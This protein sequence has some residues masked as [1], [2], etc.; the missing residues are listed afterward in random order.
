MVFSSIP[1]LYYFLPAVLAVYF[2]CL[3]RG[4]NA[5]LLAFS[6]FFY[7][8][9]ELKFLLLMGAAIIQGYVF[10]I[11][12]D[13][14]QDKKRRRFAA[15]TS[16]GIS[17]GILA[18]FKY[19]GFFDENFRAATGLPLPPLQIALPVGVSFYTF[20]ILSYTA[21]VYRRSIPAERNLIHF[22]CYVSMFP[23]L[24][25]GPIVRYQDIAGELK[26]RSA[27]L[28][29]VYAGLRRFL[30]GLGKKVLL[31]DQFYGLCE[32]FQQSAEKP[33]L[34]CWMHAA[35]FALYV[36]YDFSGYSDM[37]IGMG[38]MLGFTFPENFHYPF[39]SR[40]ASEF[41]RRW[42][43]TL[44]G[45]FRDYVYIPLGGSRRG[46]LRWL[47]NLFVVWFLT[48]L[49]HGAAWNF[50]I[51]GLFFGI[52]TAAEKL[53]YGKY[54]ERL[55]R[56]AAGFYTFLF[57]TVSFVIFGSPSVRAALDSV[58]GLFGGGGRPFNTPEAAYYLGSFAPL[59]FI[60]VLGS[61]PAP[62]MLY[63]KLRE[64]KGPGR[65]L[66]AAEPL[67]LTGLLLLCTA[68]LADESFQ[69]FLYFRF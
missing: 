53:W 3:K 36:Y 43:M 40:S 10:G 12:T 18:F 14:Q 51:W 27:D 64:K 31:A 55:P 34:F 37:A 4:R 1:F 28:E 57:V 44:G 61:T 39:V 32:I 58:G 69:P 2:V 23:Q 11:L 13:R 41:W 24:I 16:A 65:V 35:A 38:K 19:A 26:N 47:R 62:K 42:H 30:S 20:Q 45:W 50:V 29:K 66:R 49:W 54:L 46:K 59:L 56:A 5:V 67:L 48:G 60:G 68:Y 6:L 25:A 8:Y 7:G 15:V 22:A 52:L 9:G 63:E 17:L 33:V 21:D